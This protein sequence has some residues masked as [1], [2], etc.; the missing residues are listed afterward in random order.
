MIRVIIERHIANSLAVHYDKAARA[1]LQQA[2]Q[3]HGFISGEALHN[4]ADT[5]HRILI[6]TY[7]TLEDWQRWLASDE[8]KRLMEAIQPMLQ[9]D[10]KVTILAH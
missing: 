5:D 9:T 8:R 10:E 3:A 7:R 2:M 6:V 1:T 4:L